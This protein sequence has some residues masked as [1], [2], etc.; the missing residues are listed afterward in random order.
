MMSDALSFSEIDGQQAEL[1]PDR[2]V[3]Q[4]SLLD[5]IFSL[6]NSIFG[7]VGL[8]VTIGSTTTS[9]TT[10]GTGTG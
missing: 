6:V 7:F 10:T 5:S 1:L 8:P 4:T 2:A 3:M 9:T